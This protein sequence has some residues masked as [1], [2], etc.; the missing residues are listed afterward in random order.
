MSVKI[1]CSFIK[2]GELRV[3]EVEPMKIMAE[4][5]KAAS[6]SK[7]FE[8]FSEQVQSGTMELEEV[9]AALLWDKFNTQKIA[10]AMLDGIIERILQQDGGRNDN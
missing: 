9:Q 6:E 3:L 2:D 1:M 4:V 10:D 5:S 7:T 8:D